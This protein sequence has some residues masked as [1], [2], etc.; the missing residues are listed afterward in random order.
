[1]S[2]VQEEQVPFWRRTFFGIQYW[3][4]A[5]ILLIIIIWLVH[6]QGFFAGLG[7]GEAKTTSFVDKASLQPV[8]VTPVETRLKM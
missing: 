5:I 8:V 2:T 3:L 1:M 6:R 7:L 4:I